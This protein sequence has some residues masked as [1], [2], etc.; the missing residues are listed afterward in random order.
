[1]TL[2]YRAIWTDDSPDPI[3][4][5]DGQLAAWAEA[6]GLP[7]ASVTERGSWSDGLH[8]VEV[9]RARSEAGSILRAT[10]IEHPP[11][12]GIRTT[13]ATAISTPDGD[14]AT[15]WVD[16][17]LDDP[18]EGVVVESPGLVRGLLDAGRSPAVG[19][20]RLSTTPVVPSPDHV[21]SLIR[22]ILDAGRHVPIVVF[23]S[24]AD[25]PAADFRR[26][27]AA[28]RSLAGVVAVKL[29]SPESLL[30]FNDSLPL[31]L[32]IAE[33]EVRIYLPD[34]DLEDPH[35]ADRHR[36]VPSS[37]FDEP[38]SGAG[39]LLRRRLLGSGLDAWP[40]AS[41]E[42]LRHLV[43][44]PGDD[45]PADV[46]AAFSDTRLAMATSLK[47]L[48]ELLVVSESEAEQERQDHDAALVALRAL[49]EQLERDHQDDLIQLEDLTREL[50][51]TRA[52]LR[53]LIGRLGRT[54]GSLP[55]GTADDAPRT[56]CEVVE[57][58]RRELTFVSIPDGA[59]RDL[60][61]L[62]NSEKR[63]VWAAVA[64]QGLRALEGYAKAVADGFNGGG[65]HQWCAQTGEWPTAK[66]ARKESETVMSSERLAAARHL[67]VDPAV[68]PSGFVTMEA[69][70][71]IQPGGGQNIPR[72]YF[73]DDTKGVTGKVHVGFFGPHDLMP[74]TRTN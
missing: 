65:F 35:D 64:W 48:A 11:G 53:T 51:A 66:L 74:N 54:A 6:T 68:D 41:W 50:G 29:L 42:R 16:V 18:H 39:A 71:K 36:S 7:A 62:D 19:R 67:P 34:L 8:D 63:T 55:A 60:H 1:M 10:I 30:A 12:A 58:A 14:R 37:L 33:S 5:L 72:I 44:R 46:P 69:H 13:T 32:R 26:A 4:L 52:A 28:A 20:V 56:S 21:L 45:D 24:G 27:L 40:P 17:E 61:R 38:A 49:V 23:T 31:D 57:R 59:P 73:H 22:D 70:L 15:Y 43:A 25:R 2:V 47:E 3:E 9:R